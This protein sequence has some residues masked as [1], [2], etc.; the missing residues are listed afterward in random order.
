MNRS[1]GVLLFPRHYSCR[2]RTKFVLNPARFVLFRLIK[3]LSFNLLCVLDLFS[4]RWQSTLFQNFFFFSYRSI[5][6]FYAATECLISPLKRGRLPMSIKMCQH[7]Y[8]CLSLI[9]VSFCLSL[10]SFFPPSSSLSLFFACLPP[11]HPPTLIP[12]H[13]VCVPEPI[14][15]F[16]N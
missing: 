14:S 7:P 16:D 11:P 5:I 12:N 10:S 6:F 15:H 3:K 8:Q 2:N 9:S 1:C 4:E 13:S